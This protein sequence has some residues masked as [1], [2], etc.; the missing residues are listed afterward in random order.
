MEPFF[1]ELWL[2]ARRLLGLRA[3]LCLLLV[4]IYGFVF[5]SVLST[6][7][8]A[9]ELGELACLGALVIAAATL[10][11]KL[12]DFRAERARR[13]RLDALYGRGS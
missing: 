6:G 5:G 3:V 12:A 7:A 13:R 4:A 11:M 2:T 9:I 8:D 10:I 1:E